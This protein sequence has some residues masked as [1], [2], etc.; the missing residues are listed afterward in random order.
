[1]DDTPNLVYRAG[2][3]LIHTPAKSI[4]ID[5]IPTPDFDGLPLGKY[6]SPET[7]LP[8]YTSRSCPYQCAFCTI[9]YASSKFRARDPQKVVDDLEN[10]KRKYNV[11]MFTFVD[12]TL[13]IP[14]LNKIT[15]EI[16]NRKLDVNWYGETRFDRRID[17]QL[18]RQMFESGCRKLQF[19]LESYNQRVLD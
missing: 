8:L 13:I 19:G 3:K 4:D 7:I 10:L 2:D 15:R 16:V 1:M 5:T 14:S 11:R 12:E 17:R 9:P 18:A 6:F